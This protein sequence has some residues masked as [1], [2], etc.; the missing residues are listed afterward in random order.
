LIPSKVGVVRITGD[1]NTINIDNQKYGNQYID[2]LSKAVRLMPNLNNLNL[3][4]N[5]ITENG[6][7]G[8][9]RMFN[10]NIQILNIADNNIGK[11]GID[12]LTKFIT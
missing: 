1:Y 3:R 2:C 10:S 7:E 11:M 8:L 5:R 12:N 4:S 9:M 6:A